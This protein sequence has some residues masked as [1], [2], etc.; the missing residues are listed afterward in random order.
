MV[1]VLSV[2]QL[3]DVGLVSTLCLC[4]QC[5]YEHLSTGFCVDECFQLSWVYS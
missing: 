4:E 1:H 5:C 2:H 3:T